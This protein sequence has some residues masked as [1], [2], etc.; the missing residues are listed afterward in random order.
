[1]NF[2]DEDKGCEVCAV[3]W[4]FTLVVSYVQYLIMK[5]HVTVAFIRSS[6]H[7]S[8]SRYFKS[9]VL[10]VIET[11]IHQLAKINTNINQFVKKCL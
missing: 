11:N 8:M 4:G 10:N 6:I 2:G 3:G 5:L 9:T 7:L 1:M